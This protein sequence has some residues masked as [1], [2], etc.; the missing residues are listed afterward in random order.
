[1]RHRIGKIITAGK[2]ALR[3]KRDWFWFLVAS[4]GFFLLFV[5]IPVWTTPGDDF[6]FHLSIMKFEVYGLMISLSFLNAY[7]ISLHRHIRRVQK[8]AVTAT[9]VGS[10]L[11]ALASGLLATVG[12]GACYSSLLALF[13][14]SGSVFIVEHRWWFAAMAGGLA[15]WAIDSAAEKIVGGCTKCRIESVDTP[16]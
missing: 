16:S 4:L 14:L 10:G 11:S 9:Q 6:F 15:I 7:V 1:M 2:H 12:C 3:T 13:G 8:A 5:M